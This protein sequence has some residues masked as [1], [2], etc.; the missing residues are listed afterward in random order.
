MK[1][2]I[3]VIGISL[4]FFLPVN[5]QVTIG[6]DLEP[7]KGILLDMKENTKTGKE[8]NA[9]KGFGLPRVALKS[10]SD[11]TVVADNSKGNDYVG[12]TVYNVTSSGELSEGIYCWFGNTWKQVVLVDNPGSDGNFLKSIDGNAY[13]WTNI[14]I[15]E[16]NFAKP[17]QKVLF[18]LKKANEGIQKFKYSQI[19]AS[20]SESNGGTG[21]FSP[22][23][24]LF[25][26]AFVYIDTLN[27]KSGATSEKYVLLEFTANITKKTINDEP[28]GA[29][30]WEKLL[31]EVL[32]TDKDDE[33]NQ[34]SKMVK[35]YTRTLS[36]P[37][38]SVGNSTVALF[39]IVPLTSLKLDKGKYAL[40]LRISNT[41]N[42]YAKN[43]RTSQYTS[44]RFQDG[45]VDFLEMS[46]SNF[47]FILYEDD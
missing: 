27:I 3:I 22:D 12:L 34:R 23:P 32:I 11:L 20:S 47:G 18:D 46:V 1:I 6:S 14:T 5:A 7:R 8:A 4:L 2:K 45:D 10:L 44:G 15:P 17:T 35:V 33:L 24:S 37:V 41:S 39:S 28:V 13:S 9:S 42:N 30:F 31:F 36:T 21:N 38:R 29:G 25:K 40:K 16:Y 19:A 26:D 43:I